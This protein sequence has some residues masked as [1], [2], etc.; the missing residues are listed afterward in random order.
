[1]TYWRKLFLALCISSWG[2]A[3][4]VFAQTT[5]TLQTIP[6]GQVQGQG[7]DGALVG[8]RVTVRGIVTGIHSDQNLQGIVYHT[9][10]IQDVPG[11]EDGDP[12]TSDGLAVFSGRRWPGVALGDEV[13]VTGNV[14]EF[15][16]LTE[17][18]DAQLDITI[19]S[20]GN[21]LPPAVELTL[22]QPNVPEA[23]EALEGMLV[24]IG[25]ARVL[26]A[27]FDGCGLAVVRVDSGLERLVR[28]SAATD[29]SPVMP[30]LYQTDVACPNIPIV[31]S[32]DVIQGLVGPLTYNFNQYKIVLQE[33]TPLEIIPAPFPPLPRAYPLTA[34]QISIASFNVENYFDTVDDTGSDAEPKPTA[35]ELALKQTKLAYTITETLRCPTVLAI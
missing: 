26:G 24:Q 14:M 2:I 32:G 34:G 28:P 17:L 12:R 20:R 30:V 19:L 18:D 10:F 11:T 31:K 33:S 6:I 1:M 8:R 29:I 27:T 9:F 21:P 13:L 16:G 23:L 22:D 15:F 35:A 4:A 5:P 7:D 25:E 3:T